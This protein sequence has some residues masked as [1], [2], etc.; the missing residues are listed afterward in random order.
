MHIRYLFPSGRFTFY[1]S[2]APR[3]AALDLTLMDT[4]FCGRILWPIIF[5]LILHG[6]KAVFPRDAITIF[7]AG[8]LVY[9][10]IRIKFIW[11][12]REVKELILELF[13]GQTDA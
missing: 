9:R 5:L 1:T 13:K 6:K 3:E 12:C 7:M 2:P 11:D 8:L 10:L 4:A